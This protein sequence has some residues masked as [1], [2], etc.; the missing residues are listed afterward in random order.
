M[1]QRVNKFLILGFHP[2]I[3][4]EGGGHKR[5]LQVTLIS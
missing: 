5:F 2:E 4:D 1:K 3:L